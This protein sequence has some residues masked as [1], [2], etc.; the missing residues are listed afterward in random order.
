MKLAN[1]TSSIVDYPI[2][3]FYTSNMPI[4][5]QSALVSNVYFFSQM[6]YR[7]FKG[8]FITSLFGSWQEAGYQGQI[9]PV[10]GLIYYITSPK[11][12]LGALTD[13]IHTIIY[14][15]FVVGSCA[16]FSKT[17]IDVSGQGPKEIAKNLKDQGMFLK[18]STDDGTYRKLK[19]L[20]GTAALLGGM[21]IGFLTIFADFLGAI[22][23][24][25]GILLTVTIIYGLYEDIVKEKSN[26]G[27]K[28]SSKR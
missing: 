19:F 1:K 24:G 11:T 2:R 21:C 22:G 25:T 3:L 17:W 14:V 13:P 5:L 23:S 20:I 27:G 16:L 7:N 9:V 15:A 28:Q 4:I 6:L 8:S 18:G 10:G 26:K 12:L